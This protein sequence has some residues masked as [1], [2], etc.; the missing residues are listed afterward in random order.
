MSEN[1]S[2]ISTE[3]L[4]GT[5]EVEWNKNMFALLL[6][7][8]TLLEKVLDSPEVSPLSFFASLQFA[9]PFSFIE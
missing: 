8:A 3:L 2:A 1:A 7:A 6:N 9:Q 4:A 5:N